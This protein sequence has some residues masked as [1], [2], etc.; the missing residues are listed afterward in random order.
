LLCSVPPRSCEAVY[1]LAATAVGFRQ[2]WAADI[3]EAGGPVDLGFFN[4]TT[5]YRLRRSADNPPAEVE[6]SCETGQEWIGTRILFRL[7]PGGS[8][9]LLRFTHA[10]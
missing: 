2:W 4:R 6:W 1:A 7:E 10:G 9:T 8:G 3:T 5:M